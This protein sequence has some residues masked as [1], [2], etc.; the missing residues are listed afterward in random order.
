VTTGRVLPQRPLQ[1]VTALREHPA[2][3]PVEPQRAGQSQADRDLRGPAEAEVE[4]GQQVRLFE[5]R[6]DEQRR[7]GRAEPGFLA[8]LGVPQK[9]VAVPATYR[10]L[11]PGLA[12]FLHAELA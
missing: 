12:Q 6:P 11:L 3:G 8:A 4:R 9:V 5:A 7:L 1:P 10:V 2:A